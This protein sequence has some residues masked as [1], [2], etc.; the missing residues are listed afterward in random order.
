MKKRGRRWR[1]SGGSA[2]GDY[3]D[4]VRGTGLENIV[5]TCN[6][7]AVMVDGRER[8]GNADDGMG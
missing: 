6:D 7:G 3:G 2:V 1:R 4:W 5:C 8:T